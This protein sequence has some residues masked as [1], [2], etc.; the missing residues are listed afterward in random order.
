[1]N[2]LEPHVPPQPIETADSEL[3]GRLRRIERQDWWLWTAAI[4]IML[5]L[6]SAVWLLSFPSLERESN[7][8]LRLQTE[9]AVRGL[10]GIVL[11]FGLYAVYQQVQIK[12]LRKHLAS[13]MAMAAALE[14]RA[15]AFEKLAILD[16][17]TGLY[18]R[19]F[20]TEVLAVEVARSERQGYTL[21]VLMLDLN[22][23][24]EIND[25]YGHPAGDLALQEFARRLKK[26]VR[27][28]DV[29]VR[30]GGDEFLV[31]LPECNA[32][33]VVHALSRLGGLEVEVEGRRIPVTFS[34]GW[35]EYQPGESPQRLLERA[36][37]ALYADKRTGQ[38][39]E[40]VR[41][42]EVQIR[43]SQKME[44]IGRLT[45]GV[46]HD[47]NNLL[48]VI[49]GFSQLVL[50]G[51]DSRNPLR[52]KVEEIH[53]AAEKATTLTRQLLAFSRKRGPQAKVLDLHVV[54]SDMEA[55]L[56]RLLG[57]KI[58]LVIPA[59]PSGQPL[60]RVRADQGQIEQ[61]ILN[62]VVNARD[63]MPQ[64]GKL[65]IETANAELDGAYAREHP[66]ARL[67]SYVRLAV[68]DTGVGMD[69]ETRSH[70]FEPFFTTK[71][72]GEGTGFGLATVYGIVKQFGGYISVD[73]EPG[74]GATFAVYLP[75]VENAVDVLKPVRP[76]QARVGRSRGAETV[77]VAES[78]DAL[79]RLTCE[80]LEMRGFD[81]KEAASGA[82]AVRI[83]AEHQGPIHALVTDTL[84]GGMSGY[85]LEQSMRSLHPETKVLFMSD[86]D[87]NPPMQHGGTNGASFLEAPFNPNDLVSK[88]RE[89]LDTEEEN[90][91]S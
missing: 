79:R 51:L 1:M 8:V 38:A 90:A 14:T 65:I 37:Q 24:K 72:E 26:S 2:V 11:L 49:R 46:T 40:R 27:S 17:L 15:E 73:S 22:R 87:E 84:V 53:K 52:A 77:L 54:T 85:E 35:V 21:T 44:V 7:P 23:L 71:G 4:V 36:D 16:P 68:I 59:G 75:R 83:F 39:E 42:A 88:L 57:E 33:E 62:L 32:A 74:L 6:T 82:E 64:G 70:I 3:I 66:G 25:Q 45:G 48:T 76:A 81:V 19:R 47:F 69:T 91:R 58:E 18:N 13:Q 34:A 30:M 60:G 56:R 43:Q 10:L 5:L 50:D 78:L 28:S 86:Y 89:L 67:G 31:L 55:M 61:V 12:R 80:F 63:A 29:P 20:A 9:L 41:E